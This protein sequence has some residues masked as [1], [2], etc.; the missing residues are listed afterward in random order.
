MVS[1]SLTTQHCLPIAVEVL[2]CELFVLTY[3]DVTVHTRSPVSL[4]YGLRRNVSLDS[5]VDVPLFSND[6]TI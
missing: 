1:C 2:V 5:N 3:V 6:W 4:K